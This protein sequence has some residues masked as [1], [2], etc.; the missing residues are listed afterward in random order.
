LSNRCV[1]VTGAAA[2]IGAAVARLAAAA[3]ARVA[4]L[5]VDGPGARRGAAE[6]ESAGATALAV[7]CDVRDEEQV[8][9]AFARIAAEFGPVR[10]VVAS[11]AIDRGGPLADLDAAT[12]DQVIAVNLRGAFLTCRAAVRQ[13]QGAGGSIVCVSSPFAFAAAPGGVGAYSASKG[14]V[15]ALVRALA[16]ECAADGI[17]VNALLPGPTDTAL[18]W[19]GV[20]EREV[21]QMRLAVAREVPLGRLADP[22]E[23]ARAA[24]WLLS[25]AASY[26]TG[27][28]LACDGGV[29]AKASVSI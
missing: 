2:G 13:M 4:L 6:L 10:G 24:I 5:D 3:G 20:D 28:Q 27:S 16:V 7:P 18:M 19:A 21:A 25:D 17:R 1:A 29:L 12:W 8:G 22:I 14:G 23:P 26:V 9:T 15:S 11:A